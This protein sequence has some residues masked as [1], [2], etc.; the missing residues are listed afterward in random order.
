MPAPKDRIHKRKDGRY[1]GRYTVHTPNGPVRRR[2]Y[3]RKYGEVQKK[4]A[5]A[6]GD[7]ARGIVFDAE[8]QTVAEY[9]SRW[10]DDS[11]RD[12]VRRSTFARYESIVRHHIAPALGR[13]KLARLTPQHVRAL[14]RQKLDSG[15]SPRSVQYIHTT[16]K[17]ALR[18]AVLD[19]AVPRNVCDAVK[20]PQVHRDEVTPLTP[21]QVRALR[22]ATAWKPSTSSR[23]TPGSGR[24]SCSA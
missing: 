7:A 9:L 16:L 15:L 23:S 10:L 13:L 3:G 6:M 22:G 14:Y 4:L 17:K 18:Q 24:A 5:E 8:K 2:V 20:P 12:T 21:D 19:G 1:E 11:V